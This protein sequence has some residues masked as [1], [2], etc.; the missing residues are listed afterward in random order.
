MNLPR[1]VLITAAATTMSLSQASAADDP[2]WTVKAPVN[3]AG[4]MSRTV[5]TVTLA[6]TRMPTEDD[7]LRLTVRGCGD[8]PWYIEESLNGTTAQTLRDS[9]KEEFDNARLNCKLADGVEERMMAGFDEAFARLKPFLPPH[10]QTVGGWQLSDE[11]GLPG[12]DGER[13][14]RMVKALATVKMTYQP[15]GTSDGASI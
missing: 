7:T 2:A 3:G 8:E 13:S 14:V 6:Y 9:A 15:S 12:D 5:D 4:A 10:R 11:G 1:S